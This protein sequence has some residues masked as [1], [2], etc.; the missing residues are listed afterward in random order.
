MPVTPIYNLPFEDPTQDE[1][2]HTLDGGSLGTEPILAVAV[3]AELA[4]IDG[5]VSTVQAAQAANVLNPPIAALR[6]S[7]NQSIPSGTPTIVEWNF[8][9]WDIGNGHSNTTNPSRYTA[10]V[11]G[12]YRVTAHIQWQGGG[13]SG[14]RFAWID[15]NGGNNIAGSRDYRSDVAADGNTKSNHTSCQVRMQAGDFIEIEVQQNSGVS[16]DINSGSAHVDSTLEVEL[17]RPV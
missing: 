3:E 8:E 12:Y 10:P 11:A 2:G 17:I 14:D 13:V 4:R 6:R 5:D 7:T 15:H 9:T 1:P 16:L